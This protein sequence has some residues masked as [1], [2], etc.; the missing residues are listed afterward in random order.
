MDMKTHV[1]PPVA[2]INHLGWPGI[3][4]QAYELS[5]QHSNV[6]VAA[7]PHNLGSETAKYLNVGSMPDATGWNPDILSEDFSAYNYEDFVILPHTTIP[8]P[9]ICIIPPMS[10][11]YFLF[12][13]FFLFFYF[14]IFFI[15]FIFF[16]F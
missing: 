8:V 9:S 15:F 11:F 7:L 10:V 16:Y 4:T 14:F 6:V 13:L 5:S 1:Y 12:F 2:Y 3:S